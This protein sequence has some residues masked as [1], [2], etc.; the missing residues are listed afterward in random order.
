MQ[1]FRQNRLRGGGAAH[2]TP[3]ARANSVSSGGVL[4][5][6]DPGEDE[7]KKKTSKGIFGSIFRKGSRDKRKDEEEKS[8]NTSQ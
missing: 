2:G 3:G 6:T 4:G 8:S 5:G 7:I 1:E